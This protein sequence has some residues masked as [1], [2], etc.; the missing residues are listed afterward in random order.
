[1]SAVDDGTGEERLRAIRPHLAIRGKV[2][3]QVRAFFRARDYLEVE[4]PVRVGAPAIERHIDAEKAGSAYLRTS[5]ELYMKRLLSAGLERLFEIG[6]CFRRGESGRFHN[7]EYTML[8][9]YRAHASYEDTIAECRELICAVCRAVNGEDS[10]VY[11]GKTVATG[12]ECCIMSVRDAFD[13]HAGWDPVS[14]YD[15]E[16]FNLDLVEKVEPSLPRDRP[17]FLK[18]YP[19]EEAALACLKSADRRVAERW[20]LYIGGVELAN[21][22]TELRSVEEQ[23]MRFEKA[24][25]ARRESGRDVYPVDIRFMESLEKGLPQCSGVALGMDRLV[26]LLCN[27]DSI[28]DVRAF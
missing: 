3:D 12:G 28:R 6:P 11:R 20:E 19:A 1:L 2:F 25:E 5:P 27:A 17:V 21:A 8:E 9:W 26:M 23:A 13:R 22:F 4:T 15:A 24:A 14:N 7:P 10:F 16:R 18:D